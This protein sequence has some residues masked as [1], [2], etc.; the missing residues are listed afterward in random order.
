LHF[1]TNSSKTFEK[2]AFSIETTI[3]DIN[4]LH[5]FSTTLSTNCIR[6]WFVIITNAKS[7]KNY[8]C[9]GSSI[10]KGI[11]EPKKLEIVIEMLGLILVGC[12][13]II[14]LPKLFNSFSNFFGRIT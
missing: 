13:V 8:F 2:I 12:F 14:A 9:R 10:L 11:M 6:R 4:V 7:S 3:L 1:S 5:I